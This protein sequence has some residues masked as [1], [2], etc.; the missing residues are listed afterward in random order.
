MFVISK[1]L[2]MCNCSNYSLSKTSFPCH[3][4]YRASRSKCSTEAPPIT[5]N[6]IEA[7]TNDSKKRLHYLVQYTCGANFA[8]S[9]NE[10]HLPDVNNKPLAQP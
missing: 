8:T 10:S 3:S 4:Y 5:K 1:N 2:V 6:F 7:K 9:G